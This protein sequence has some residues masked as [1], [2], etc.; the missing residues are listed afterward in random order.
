M[1]PYCFFAH[2]AF[3]LDAHPHSAPVATTNLLIEVSEAA[4]RSGAKTKHRNVPTLKKSEK[5][6]LASA[7]AMVAGREYLKS[8]NEFCEFP[9]QRFVNFDLMRPTYISVSPPASKVLP[10]GI[11]IWRLAES[12][13]D[14]LRGEARSIRYPHIEE[15]LAAHPFLKGVSPHHLELLALCTTP[16]EFESGQIIFLEGDPANGF[17]LIESG[18]VALEKKTS[19][20]KTVLIDT[21]SPGE[22][23]GWSWLF[24]PYLWHFDARAT[25]PCHALCLSGILLRQHRDE[26]FG[27]GHELFKRTSEVVVK[28]LQAARSKLVSI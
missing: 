13:A 1:K 12:E 10:N 17:Y 23:L 14:Q 26:D 5:T 28:R 3:A 20:G 18:K 24:P 22:P 9:T 2:V 25:E 11:K 8:E 21:V 15:R 27:L 6:E 4:L 7:V 16:T 19:A